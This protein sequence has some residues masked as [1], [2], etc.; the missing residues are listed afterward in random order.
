MQTATSLVCLGGLG[1]KKGGATTCETMKP[2]PDP[3]GKG[4]VGEKTRTACVHVRVC[5][6]RKVRLFRPSAWLFRSIATKAF[7]EAQVACGHDNCVSFVG[8]ATVR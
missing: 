2:H 1:A 5:W 8:L 7:G 3:Q 6:Y 4:D